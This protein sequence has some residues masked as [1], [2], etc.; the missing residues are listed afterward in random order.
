MNREKRLYCHKTI[1][2]LSVSSAFKKTS[3]TWFN[4][5]KNI[6]KC[7]KCKE[8]IYYLLYPQSSIKHWR[9]KI[10]YK[11]WS[12]NQKGNDQLTNLCACVK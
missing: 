5:R 12:R 2:W 10:N 7:N 8:N 6:C 4:N 9:N 3:E 11:T 1:G